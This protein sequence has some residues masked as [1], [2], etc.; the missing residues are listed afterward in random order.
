M[1][2]GGSVTF[3]SGERSGLGR[4]RT[5]QAADPGP[6][7]LEERRRCSDLAMEV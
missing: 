5:D 1:D 6:E 3:E 4:E 7:V 2:D